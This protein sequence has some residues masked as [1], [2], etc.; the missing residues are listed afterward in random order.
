MNLVTRALSLLG[1]QTRSDAYSAHY[2]AA[3]S[4]QIGKGGSIVMPYS[5][6]MV[7]ACVSVISEA[8]ASLPLMLIDGTTREPANDVPLYSVLNHAWNP[9][10]TAIEGRE[11]LA[12]SAVLTG[13]GYARIERNNAGAVVALWPLSP[14]MVN[15]DRLASGRLRYRYND[16]SGKMVTLL[17]SEVLHVRYKSADGV[18]GRSPIEVSRPTF[19]LAAQQ[20]MHATDFLRR[21]GRPIGAFRLPVGNSLGDE[22]FDRLKNDLPNGWLGGS[23]PL[24]EDGLEFQQIGL[25]HRDS[26][27]IEQVKITSL[28]ICRIY[29]VP[30]TVAGVLDNATYSNVGQEAQ[31]LVKHC[32]RPWM[33]RIEQAMMLA[34]LTP[35]GRKRYRIEHNAEG[36]LRGS[37]QE[38]F[39]SYRVAREWGWLSVNEIRERENLPGIG[40]A[41]DEY[42]A[43]LNS[44]PLASGSDQA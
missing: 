42:R 13:N 27:F 25:S 21:D 10:M 16:E 26:Q 29:R 12:A 39:E 18:V 30:A 44:E 2:L 43:P 40:S 24:L 11:H 32:L 31:A 34:L 8:T 1:L 15:V 5:L 36:L 3:R 17:D 35:Q 14:G 23:Y 38:R 7:S 19:E 28:D 20:Q 4:A 37:Q 9:T 22:A 33:V 6:P 41:G